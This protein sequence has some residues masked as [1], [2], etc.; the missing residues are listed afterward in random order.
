MARPRKSPEDRRDARHILRLTDEERAQAE[1][2]ASS[3]G[4]TL[5]EY[6]RRQALS[7]PLPERRAER[8]AT[9]ELTTAL[10]RL[11]VN[12]NQIARHMNAGHSAPGD[13]PALIA[14][15][16]QHLERLSDEPRGDRQGP[17]L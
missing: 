7:R 13:L 16:A 5:S 10:L 6:F 4:L 2:R 17:Q 1:A 11:G 15:I 3:Y 9:A 14:T 12:L 8:Q